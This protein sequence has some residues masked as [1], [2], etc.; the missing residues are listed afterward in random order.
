LIQGNDG[1]LYGTAQVGGFYGTVFQITPGGVLT[2]LYTFNGIDGGEPMGAL[3]QGTDGDFYGTT[4]T[5]GSG[6]IGAWGTIFRITSTGTLTT[7]H[8][9]ENADGAV[10]YGGLVQQTNGAFYGTT[11]SGG[12]SGDGT[13]Y[14]LITSLHPFVKTLP[15]FGTAG[16]TVTI[17][18]SSLESATITGVTFSGTAAAFTNLGQ[19][20]LTAIVPAG[21]TSGTVLVTTTSALRFRA[22]PLTRY[23]LNRGGIARPPSCREECQAA[24]A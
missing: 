12:T 18:G 6:P 19:Q 9:F 22:T 5:G 13:I 20:G 10:P 8:T 7:L 16:S 21:A 14:R 23:F 15:A 24:R 4:S 17:L 1:N 3:V 11:S 2:T